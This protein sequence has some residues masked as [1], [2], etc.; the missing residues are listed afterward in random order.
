MKSYCQLLVCRCNTHKFTAVDKR[1]FR[2]YACTFM[3]TKDLKYRNANIR[4][5]L[6]KTLY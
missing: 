1:H 5:G 2:T 6:S 3:A 4:K